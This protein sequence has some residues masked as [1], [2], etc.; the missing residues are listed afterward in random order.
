MSLLALTL[1]IISAILHASW[2]VFGK[3]AAHAGIAFYGLACLA[4]AFLSLPG[5]LQGLGWL[6]YLPASFWGLVLATGIAQGVYMAG[7]AGCYRHGSLGIAYPLARAVPV[8]LVPVG[9]LLLFQ[10][11][12]STVAGI[13]MLLIS[14]GMFLL[15][16]TG[17]P[18]P[19]LQKT[20]FFALVAAFGTVSYSLIDFHALQGLERILPEIAPWRLMLFYAA[21]QAI[22]SLAVLALCLADASV[23]RA[24]VQT[25]R[26]HG[27]LAMLAG[28]IMFLTYALVL[29]SLFFVGDVSYAVAVRQISIPVGVAFGVIFLGESLSLRQ[30]VANTV[31]LAGLLLV[32]LG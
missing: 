23:R 22:S 30:V 19:Q 26:Q 3:Q 17:S 11:W 13:G 27:R 9:S 5:L 32:V 1:L 12:P 31:L 14:A 15:I 2:N 25:F 8:L 18:S 29:L 10:H 7:L 28:A 6:P 4:A 20:L 16:K 24:T 21:C